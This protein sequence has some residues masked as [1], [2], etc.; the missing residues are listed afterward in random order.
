MPPATRFTRKA[1]VDAA[2]D[3]A[4]EKG[5]SGLSAR[6]LAKA[7]GCSVAPIYECFATM[8]D[9]RA[10]VVQRIFALSDKLLANQKGP[11]MFENIGKASLSF[12]REYPTLFRELVLEPNPYMASYD[13]VETAMLAALATDEVMGTW[14]EQE[15]RRIFL[16]LRIF[17]LGLS[18][19][20]AN[21]HLPSWID[22]QEAEKLLLETGDELMAA[23]NGNRLSAENLQQASGSR[24]HSKGA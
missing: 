1:I 10:A 15:R 22:E 14:T 13:Q 23:P 19:M 24:R 9:L 17:Q 4:K 11:H 5:L 16:K 20:T 2:F 6:G 3:L 18:A 21:G 12:A 7:L 8:E